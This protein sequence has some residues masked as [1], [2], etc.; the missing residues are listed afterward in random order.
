[1]ITLYTSTLWID[2]SCANNSPPE[3]Y[4]VAYLPPYKAVSAMSITLGPDDFILLP[5][6]P[7]RRN[8][9]SRR[10]TVSTSFEQNSCAKNQSQDVIQMGRKTQSYAQ[11]MAVL[12]KTLLKSKQ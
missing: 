10:R 4:L 1:M 6:Q 12:P 7:D 9:V 8:N 3:I 2:N 11:D 5:S